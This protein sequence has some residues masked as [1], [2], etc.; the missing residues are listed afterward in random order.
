MVATL[1]LTGGDVSTVDGR[2]SIIIAVLAGG[3][4][5]PMIG[6]ML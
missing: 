6:D 5:G 3:A 2:L 1:F 4:F